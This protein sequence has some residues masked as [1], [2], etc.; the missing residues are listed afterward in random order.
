MSAVALRTTSAR[1]VSLSHATAIGPVHARA[2]VDVDTDSAAVTGLFTRPD[3][4][5]QT[6]SLAPRGRDFALREDPQAGKVKWK[7]NVQPLT[8]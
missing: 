6:L 4:G 5:V 1:G 7:V 3:S 8:R 2:F